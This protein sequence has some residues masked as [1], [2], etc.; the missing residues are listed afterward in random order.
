M[1]LPH[2][3]WKTT[4]IMATAAAGTRVG[5]RAAIQSAARRDSP[6][7]SPISPGRG[8]RSL[9]EGP[10][11]Q[12]ADQ[13]A[14][15]ASSRRRTTAQRGGDWG[16]HRSPPPAARL[17]ARVPVAW[18]PAISSAARPDGWSAGQIDPKTRTPHVKFVGR[19]GESV[20]MASTRSGQVISGWSLALITVRAGEARPLRLFTAPQTMSSRH[21]GP[22]EIQGAAVGRAAGIR[23]IRCSPSSTARWY[24]AAP[25][26]STPGRIQLREPVMATARSCW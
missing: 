17:P 25:G 8:F 10:G 5:V 4:P 26:P 22:G 13:A 15:P 12:L 20:P 11:T 18:R 6:K 23:L 7:P 14:T 21:P 19:A 1:G 24:P 16:L 2:A 3:G 9:R